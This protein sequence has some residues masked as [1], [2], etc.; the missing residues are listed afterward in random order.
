MKLITK[1]VENTFSTD[2]ESVAD[3]LESIR[4]DWPERTWAIDFAVK[5]NEVERTR[6]P[7]YAVIE[8]LID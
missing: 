2:I 5:A 8:I 3:D 1:I 7:G 6:I 4:D